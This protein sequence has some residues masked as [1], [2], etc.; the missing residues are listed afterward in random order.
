[1][2]LPLVGL[3]EIAELLGVSRQRA[4]QLARTADFPAPQAELDSGRI[5]L[6]DDFEQW[7]RSE[8]RATRAKTNRE[9]LD[10]LTLTGTKVAR[11]VFRSAYVNARRAGLGRGKHQG[12]IEPTRRAAYD[13]AF[14]AARSTDASFR[15]EAPAGWFDEQQQ[16]GGQR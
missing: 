15:A 7:A 6:R 8:G 12:E 10:D 2:R 13:L 4:D 11:G 16:E 5:W 9:E 14:D 1:M 3:G